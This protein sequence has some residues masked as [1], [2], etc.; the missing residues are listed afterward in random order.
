MKEN[1]NQ[2][3]GFDLVQIKT[4]Q[5]ALFEENYLKDEEINLAT[6]LSFSISEDNMSF[7]VTSKF[8]FEMQ[9]KPFMSVQVS[10]FF[11]INES[12]WNSFKTEKG[13]LFPKG[14]VSHMSML[15]VG[16]SRGVLHSKTSGT[17]FNKYILPTINVAKMVSDDVFFD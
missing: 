17:K 14:F 12:S 1:N 4:E 9:S 3:I 16:T 11:N 8:I 10:C 5:F 13:I 15:T 2:S 6:N 7:M